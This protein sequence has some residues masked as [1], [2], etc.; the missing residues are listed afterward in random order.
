MSRLAGTSMVA[1]ATA[2]LLASLSLVAWRQARA[3]ETLE[4]LD[5]LQ[6]ELALSQAEMAD[7]GSRIRILESRGRIVPEARD[8]LGMRIPEASEVVILAGEGS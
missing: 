3:L 6:R 4:I 7:L 2:A 5:G 8:E 1:L